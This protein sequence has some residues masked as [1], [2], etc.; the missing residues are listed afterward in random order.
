MKR[1]L[2]SY[3]HNILPTRDEI[4]TVRQALACVADDDANCDVPRLVDEPANHVSACI[5]SEINL[6]VAR[7]RARLLRSC[8]SDVDRYCLNYL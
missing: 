5:H 6:G 7:L 3:F 1:F 2:R 8:Y 4:S